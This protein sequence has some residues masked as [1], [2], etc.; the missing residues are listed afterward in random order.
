[1]ART[2]TSQSPGFAVPQSARATWATW[3]AASKGTKKEPMSGS[4]HPFSQ[5]LGQVHVSSWGQS[6][7]GLC[8]WVAVQ[9]WARCLPSLCLG[10]L[11]CKSNPLSWGCH[12]GR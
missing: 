7:C 12:E 8:L 6:C 4:L 5:P 10:L 2:V 9:P 1:M 11:F 3:F